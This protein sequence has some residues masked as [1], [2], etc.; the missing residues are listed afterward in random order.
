M[1]TLNQIRNT[2]QVIAEAHQ[3][4]R[5]FGFDN[6]FNF[7]QSEDLQFPVLYV[8]QQP[9]SVN[10]QSLR[11]T[12]D[13]YILD[14][15]YGDSDTAGNI[16]EVLSDTQLIALDVV[17]QL[18]NTEYAFQLDKDATALEPLF[19]AEGD[20]LAGYKLSVTIEEP[21][22]YWRCSAPY[23][24]IVIED[25][26][27]L[28]VTSTNEKDPTVP[29]YVK[30]ITEANIAAW[31]NAYSASNP[32][33]F[34]TSGQT[35]GFITSAQI[36][37]FI[38][39]GQASAAFYSVNNPSG[40]VTSGQASAAFYPIN[41][42]SG[43]VTSETDPTV[44]AVI[45][46]MPTSGSAAPLGWNGSAYVLLPRSGT[47]ANRPTSPF[48][49]QIYFATDLGVGN[50][51]SWNGTYWEPSGK[52]LTLFNATDLQS[53]GATT[54]ETLVRSVIVPA[55]LLV[56]G[57]QIRVKGATNF[58]STNTNAKGTIVR[59]GTNTVTP[60]SNFNI[61]QRL[62]ASSNSAGFVG[63]NKPI[64][65]RANQ[66]YVP[67]PQ[68]EVEAGQ[69]LGITPNSTTVNLISNSFAVSLSLQKGATNDVF[70]NNYFIV[71]V[72]YP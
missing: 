17:S 70:E 12:F 55:N 6:E 20:M 36:S 47:W 49:G 42:P 15:Y 51:I 67:T 41:N 23:D 57:C 66:I 61:T 64:I 65:V 69:S 16:T 24:F 54:S 44:P 60:L 63:F 7:G 18:A 39:S 5:G 37:G 40:F 13:C 11:R 72:E 71:E 26:E 62:I 2:F 56:A 68:L 3:Q 48:T 53:V 25:I 9:G 34:V 14:R 31:N 45:K 27:G 29:T 59:I 8:M 32:S 22:D 30:A 43:F 50:L 28:Q 38:T 21:F 35:S 58:S 46:A 4:I 10:G 1:L 52:K 19:Q 33:G